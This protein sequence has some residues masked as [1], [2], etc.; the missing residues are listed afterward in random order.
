MPKRRRNRMA[1]ML[2]DSAADNEMI[3][4][5]D[6]HYGYN[7][8]FIAKEDIPKT[9]FGCHGAI[10]TFTWI[11]MPFSL[12]NG[13]TTYQRAMNFIFHDMIDDFMEVYMDNII[14]K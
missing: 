8:M 6:G 14:V 7:Q 5:I 9:A 12:K 3:S 4:I 13:R 2:V 11:V 1:D 10:G